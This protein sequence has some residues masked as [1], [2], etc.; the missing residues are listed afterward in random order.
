LYLSTNVRNEQEGRRDFV[1]TSEDDKEE[2]LYAFQLVVRSSRAT[3]L[4]HLAQHPEHASLFDSFLGT[5]KASLICQEASTNE[6]GVLSD[7]TTPTQGDHNT[8][9]IRTLTGQDEAISERDIARDMCRTLQATLAETELALRT[10]RRELEFTI[11]E[12]DNLFVS[13]TALLELRNS[14]LAALEVAKAEKVE[15]EKAREKSEEKRKRERENK[16]RME[17][18]YREEMARMKD[19]DCEKEARMKDDMR[20]KQDEVEKQLRELKTAVK[21]MLDEKTTVELA[22]QA[23]K[24]KVQ[25]METDAKEHGEDMERVCDGFKE[26]LVTFR[27]K[28]AEHRQWEHEKAEF[29]KETD[30]LTQTNKMLTQENETLSEALNHSQ[31]GRLDIADTIRRERGLREA[32]ER[33][34]ERAERACKTAETAYDDLLHERRAT[35]REDDLRSQSSTSTQVSLH[36]P[37]TAKGRVLSSHASSS[38]GSGYISAWEISRRT[39]HTQASS[40]DT[41][42][43]TNSRTDRDGTSEC[44]GRCLS[45]SRWGSGSTSMTLSLDE[46]IK[47]RYQSALT[48]V[49][50]LTSEVHIIETRSRYELSEARR[51]EKSL[52]AQLRAARAALEAA[53]LYVESDWAHL[54]PS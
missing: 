43:S 23:T 35:Q 26:E 39:S 52:H 53:G 7:T 49:H 1:S 40:T 29:K 45:G 12:K 19:E 13:W 18:I 10:A 33:Q 27:A 6:P 2:E 3:L 14:I 5:F 21:A 9:T 20:R 28:D 50:R 51:K 24:R 11:D 31:R 41:V 48:D 8:L 44:G 15:A 30:D 54:R 42:S 32:A 25:E 47:T 17:N 22:L 37:P 46:D 4:T 16:L 34:R 36:S 38:S